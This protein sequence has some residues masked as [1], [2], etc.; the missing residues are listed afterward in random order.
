MYMVFH[1]TYLLLNS[2]SGFTWKSGMVKFYVIYGFVMLIL[3]AF[4]MA[5]NQIM[6]QLMW[7]EDRNFPGGPFDYYMAN[8][9]LWINILG[10][11][12]C[13]VGNYMNDA[14]L[15]LQV[16]II[17]LCCIYLLIFFFT[18]YKLYRLYIIYS[19]DWRVVVA[20]FI[21]FLGTIGISIFNL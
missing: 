21:L 17:F 16:H 20:P 1:S 2:R 12:T 3:F 10:T 14:L 6:G 13:I 4:A 11:A 5:A 7:I 15:V 8:S 19:G 9:T 18:F